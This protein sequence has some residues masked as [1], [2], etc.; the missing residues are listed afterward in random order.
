V[1][2]SPCHIASECQEIKKLVEQFCK[3]MQQQ[4]QDGAPSHQWEGKQKVDYQKEKDAEM[5]FQDASTESSTAPQVGGNP[6][7]VQLL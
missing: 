1:H 6:S 2:N 4:C 3:K 5:E 7:W